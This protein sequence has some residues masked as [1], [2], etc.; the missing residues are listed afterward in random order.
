MAGVIV[1]LI[2]NTA[3]SAVLFHTLLGIPRALQLA[4]KND[5][6]HVI[7]IVRAD[8]SDL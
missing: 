6:P 2:N 3:R 7:R 8:V 1:L 5:L 4:D